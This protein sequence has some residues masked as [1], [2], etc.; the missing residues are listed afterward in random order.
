MGQTRRAL[1]SL[2]HMKTNLALGILLTF[3]CLGCSKKTANDLIVGQWRDENSTIEYFPNGTKIGVYDSGMRMKGKWTIED[4][5]VIFTLSNN[6][7]NKN[8]EHRILKLDRNE[9]V[10][11]NLASHQVFHA[12]RLPDDGMHLEFKRPKAE[13][14]PVATP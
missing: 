4:N 8:N 1:V 9:L 6:K 12:K 5:V 14:G 11:E 13:P 3:L 2:G 10:L 7:R